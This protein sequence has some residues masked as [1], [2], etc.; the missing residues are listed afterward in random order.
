MT[1]NCSAFIFKIQS[2]SA[3]M[4]HL[5]S[6]L[7]HRFNKFIKFGLV[8]ALGLVVDMGLTWSIKEYVGL[9][10]F[11]ANAIGFIT[12][13]I[14]N[15]YLNKI[16]TFQQKTSSEAHQPL[17]FFLFSLIGLALNSL[18]ILFLFEFISIN[19]YLSKCIATLV[20]FF[21]NF[22]MNKKFTFQQVD[23]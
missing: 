16:W 13:V 1:L 12:A 22:F 2:T 8:G 7:F 5:L 4:F 14:S 15:F 20:V 6:T 19:F 3:L 21:W 10:P 17:L 9:N 11:I 23:K 18:I